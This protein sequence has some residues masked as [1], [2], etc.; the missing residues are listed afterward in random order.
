[1]K[2]I[3]LFLFLVWFPQVLLTAQSLRAPAYP[4]ITHNTYFS[5]WS[6]GDGLAQ[7]PTTHWSGQNASLLGLVKVDGQAYR[8]LGKEPKVYRTVAAAADETPYSFTYTETEPGAGWMNPQFS[9]SSWKSGPA[10]FGDDK[11]RA[12]TLWESSNL[13]VRRTFSLDGAGTGNLYLKLRHDDDV[14]VYLNGEEVYRLA[15]WAHQYQYIPIPA[16]IAGKLKKEGNVLAIHVANTA[17]GRLLD[18]GLVREEASN[19]YA[20][21]V[22]AVQK[23]VELNATQTIYRFTCGKVDVTATFTSPL[24]L[25]NLEVLARPVTYVSVKAESNDKASHEVQVYLGASSDLAV[26]TPEQEVMSQEYTAEKLS[27]LKTGTKEQPMFREK[28]EKERIDWGYFYVAVPTAAK[29]IQYISPVGK[30]LT[31]FLSAPVGNPENTQQSRNLV[32]STIL[33]FG[34]VGASA[35]EQVF[36]LGYDEGYSVQ[37]FG[38]N[39]KPWW[40]NNAPA[41]MEKQLAQASTDYSRIMQQCQAFDRQMYQAAERSGGK[42]YADLCELAYRQAIAAHTLVKSPT[43]ETLFLSKENYSGGFIG[44]VDVTYPSAPLFLLYNPELL[45]GMLNG[46]FYYSES[47]KWKKPYPAHDL[48]NYPFANGQTYGEDMPVEEAGNMLIL[49]AAIAKAEGNAGYAEKH[50]PTLTT[51]AEFLRKSGFDPENQLSTDDFAGHLARNAN[52]SVKAIEALASYGMLADMLGKPDVARQYK[53]VAQEMAQNWMKLAQDGD[54]YTLAFGKPGTWSQKYNLAWDTILDINIF[55]KY[56][57]EKEVGYYLRKQGTYGLPL[58]SRK[59]YTKSDWIIWTATLADNPADFKAIISP[60]WKYANETSSRVPLSDW[61]ETTD[62]KKTGFQARSVV[63]GYFMKLLAEK[64]SGK[65]A[66]KA[67]KR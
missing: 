48:G 39:L 25:N 60:V 30:E 4:L 59:T 13:W 27:I 5:V 19:A 38:Q 21:V 40:K 6:F 41:T 29:A 33:P 22:P 57:R 34:K 58:D 20:K 24:L 42:E 3:C 44:T 2:R 67:G 9:A 10:P 46:I 18:A 15:G 12:K 36:L 26:N 62:G 61:H 55:P 63:G 64:L 35:K 65:Q 14:E 54:H 11:A 37:F 50:W 56:V 49:A 66:P 47:G 28:G 16:A 52:L 31:P 23:S 7:S 51:W 53:D 17:G 32:L 1:M 45:K 8:F 43:G